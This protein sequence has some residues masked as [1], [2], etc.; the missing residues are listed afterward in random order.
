MRVSQSLRN[1]S[2]I[3]QRGALA[4]VASVVVN[5]VVRAIL[6]TLFDLPSEF[7]PLQVG[8]IVTLTAVFTLIAV[9]VFA[10]VVRFTQ[11]PI[12]TY[13]VIAGAA[14]VVSIIPNIVSALNPGAIPFP[15]PGASAS[16]FLALIVFHVVAYLI[17]VWVLTTTPLSTRRSK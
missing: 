12:R 4:I 6:S 15:F 11:R 1:T 16:A 17:T 5:V 14:F 9:V 8:A 7:P 2:S 13:H 3:W 10:L